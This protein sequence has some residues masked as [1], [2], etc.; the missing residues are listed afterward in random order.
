MFEMASSTSQAALASSFRFRSGPPICRKSLM[1]SSSR[2]MSRPT[3]NLKASKP[4]PSF[5]SILRRHGF[6]LANI[7]YPRDP[8]TIAIATAGQSSG[9]D[10]G[11]LSQDVVAGSVDGTVHE[12]AEID[13]L[14][15]LLEVGRI[16]P[17]KLRAQLLRYFSISME[18]PSLKRV[19]GS[20]SDISPMPTM[21]ESVSNS[22]M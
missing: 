17:H 13:I 22:R 10:S 3:L 19:F 1:R 18:E 6:G 12:A 15:E 8:N 16:T 11:D 21:P 2:S 9:R 5:S 7:G 20:M 4:C 14:Y